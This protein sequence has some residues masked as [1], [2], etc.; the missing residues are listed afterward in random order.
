MK[1]NFKR[2]MALMLACLMVFGTFSSMV[3]AIDQNECQ[4]VWRD[5]IERPGDS[6]VVEPTCL[7]Q[8]YT[9][10]ICEKCGKRDIKDITPALGHDF[11]TVKVDPTCQADGKITVKCK[12]CD[13]VT[14]DDV[15]SPTHNTIVDFDRSGD[16]DIIVE[17]GSEAHGYGHT[18]E[19]VQVN[20][21]K[22]GEI[23]EYWLMCTETPAGEGGNFL[24]DGTKVCGFN[25][26]GRNADGSAGEGVKYDVKTHNYTEYSKTKLLEEPTCHSFGILRI[27]C[28]AGCNEWK[29][30]KV[31]MIPHT[32]A[33]EADK[34]P[35]CTES[36]W[37]AK[38]YCTV[39]GCGYESYDERPAIGH[40][41]QPVDKLP[42]CTDA[43][44]TTFV[45]DRCGDSYEGDDIPALG[46]TFEEWYVAEEPDCVNDGLLR[47]DC[48]G[49][50]YFETEIL[51]KRGHKWSEWDVTT[52]DCETVGSRTRTCGVCGETET[53]T[54]ILGGHTRPIDETLVYYVVINING[55]ADVT[56]LNETYLDN[57]CGEAWNCTVCGELQQV[58]LD[59]HKKHVEKE[60]QYPATCIEEGRYIDYCDACKYFNSYAMPIAD[61]N[62]VTEKIPGYAPTCVT[63]GKEDGERCVTCGTIT[64]EQKE[65]PATGIHT[66][67]Y[68]PINPSYNKYASETAALG[69][70][71]KKPTC[72]ED[73]SWWKR[74][75]VCGTWVDATSTYNPGKW[76]AL[77]CDFQ[78]VAGYDA[79]CTAPGLSDG[80]QCTRCFEWE[81]EQEVLPV[82]PHPEDK[83]VE[84]GEVSANCIREGYLP[85]TMCSVCN[86]V[87]T[88]P[89]NVGI[90]KDY[91]P[92][93][94]YNPAKKPTCTEN[95]TA[96]LICNS[97]DVHDVVVPYEKLPEDLKQ[98]YKATGHTTDVDDQ[99]TVTTAATCVATGEIVYYCGNGCGTVMNTVILEIDPTNHDGK[100]VPHPQGLNKVYDASGNLIKSYQREPNCNYPGALWFTCVC[101][102]HIET[103]PN[104]DPQAF[105]HTYDTLIGTTDYIAPTCNTVGYEASETY[106]CSCTWKY[107]AY[108]YVT[109]E[110]KE[111][112]AS[113]QK[114]LVFG[115][116]EILATGHAIVMTSYTAPDCENDAVVTAVCLTCG[117]A[118]FTL[119]DLVTLLGVPSEMLF[120][121]GHNYGSVV[122]APSCDENG[123][124]LY[125]CSNC[126]DAYTDTEV[127]ATG[128]SYDTVVTAPTCFVDGYTTYTCSVCGDSYIDDVIPASHAYT[129]EVI[130]PTC[131]KVGYVE[132]SCSACGDVYHEDEV[133]ALGHDFVAAI[134]P[135][136]CTEDGA[137]IYTC[138]RANCDH[139]IDV[140]GHGF[141]Y[142]E[143]LPATGHN[144][145]PEAFNEPCS[146]DYYVVYTCA[147]GDTY[148]VEGPVENHVAYEWNLSQVCKDPE[149]CFAP[150][151]T[152][153][154]QGVGRLCTVCKECVNEAGVDHAEI[155]AFDLPHDWVTYTEPSIAGHTCGNITFTYTICVQCGIGHGVATNERP[156]GQIW[157]NGNPVEGVITDYKPATEHN[158]V[159]YDKTLG[160]AGGYKAPGCEEDGWYAQ[161]CTICGILGEKTTIP[162]TGHAHLDPSHYY[163]DETTG[164]KHY[165]DRYEWCSN[166]CGY[167]VPGHVDVRGNNTCDVRT[168]VKYHAVSATQCRKTTYYIAYCTECEY[169]KVE[170]IIV[171]FQAHEMVVDTVYNQQNAATELV[172]GSKRIYC[173]N[174]ATCDCEDEI[175]GWQ[176]ITT[177]SADLNGK[178][179]FD[180]DVYACDENGN[181][182]TENGDEYGMIVNG[183]YMAVKIDI[184][185]INVDLWGIYFDL[186]FDNINLEFV[187]ALEDGE[188][189]NTYRV[190]DNVLR[191]AST[192]KNGQDLSIDSTEGAYE[193]L[194][195]I[196][197][198][199]SSAYEYGKA[200]IEATQF[201]YKNIQVLEADKDVITSK[202]TFTNIGATTI[203]MAG[204]LNEDGTHFGL[205]DINALVQLVI[206]GE[207]DARADIDGDGFINGDDFTDLREIIMSYGFADGATIYENLLNQ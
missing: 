77:G 24:P 107:M 27:Y 168:E 82:I 23:A 96:L 72:D 40:D 111:L 146:K 156:N 165:Y 188:L 193:Y 52:A 1:T 98:Y 84:F 28:T 61:H 124:T 33:Y 37:F 169:E 11:E 205:V 6:A 39:E 94:C 196:F 15:L 81:T 134:N 18:F 31:D 202:C 197:A 149:H 95:G 112:T 128:H 159:D 130:A 60:V 162:A 176:V 66:S 167:K 204:N 19:W 186:E 127:E 89:V 142:V 70:E 185:G 113:C 55:L 35:T 2:F 36:G 199:K 206:S 32:L 20:D 80:S 129:S 139:G 103:D 17:A 125:T 183:G 166:G 91:H 115:G 88:E 163:V 121:S 141:G 117:N 132:Y 44:K 144:H 53:E 148:K 178:A 126:G 195:L 201:S 3:T 9:W 180:T 187:G 58:A 76:S 62:K 122:I 135:A 109:G 173:K 181:R 102:D 29:D 54:G 63:P 100:Y 198:V 170:D 79:T 140:N 42:T 120:S 83:I 10:I 145:V 157:E 64:I 153:S 49:C 67:F 189:T 74:C 56:N 151:C 154:G 114:T 65:I 194:T 171:T 191:V 182:Y 110:Y 123:Y 57:R 8:G 90:N 21:A 48:V 118:D 160:E 50:D 86:T 101:G 45:C 14:Q 12:R 131:T 85:G 13:L 190:S 106:A 51:E 138:Q 164:E 192:Y 93:E 69:L 73:G 46:H 7:D 4:H 143:I 175:C 47:R 104:Y 87:I 155:P 26:Y 152:T 105:Q 108:D 68:L 5:Y 78:P 41:Y 161:Y 38:E 30:V 174:C 184:S 136:T 92:V 147:C 16:G 22:C 172:D 177:V 25:Y 97:C 119:E 34:A 207:Y 59:H 203:W 116:E 158:M 71:F 133:E 150:T 179:R 137:A 99:I 43:G 75:G 200:N